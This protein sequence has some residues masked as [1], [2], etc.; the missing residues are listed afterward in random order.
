MS[1]GRRAVS[2]EEKPENK[3]PGEIRSLKTHRGE[4]RRRY[5]RDTAGEESGR[6]SVEKTR[7]QKQLNQR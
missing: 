6:D 2:E 7:R 4:K 3:D 5:S 1:W